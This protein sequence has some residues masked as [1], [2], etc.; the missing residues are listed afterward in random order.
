MENNII[1]IDKLSYKYSSDEDKKEILAVDKVDINIKAGEFVAILG[2]NGSGKSTV[3][4]HI[5]ALLLPT[6][7]TVTV[8]NFNTSN[9]NGF[10]KSR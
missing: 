6:E 4:K 9:P 10:S 3:A 8:D 5:N 1:K 7:G 2:H